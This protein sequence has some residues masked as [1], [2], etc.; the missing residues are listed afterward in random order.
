MRRTVGILGGMGP[1]ATVLL[2][3]QVIAAVPARDDADHV[4][5]IVDQNRQ[6]PSRIRRL[7]EGTGEDP[8]PVLAAMA[9][10]L[11]GR[12]PQALAMP[13]NTAHA[14][15][16]RDPGGSRAVPRHGGAVGREGPRARGEG[17]RSASSP[18]PPCAAWVSSTSRW[19][20]RG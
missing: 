14:Y 13:C 18:R 16:P 3:Q 10:R 11:Q 1:E 20:R 17:A 6:V 2:M 9:R 4:P 15:A 8:R 5:L 19:R 12:G 7:I